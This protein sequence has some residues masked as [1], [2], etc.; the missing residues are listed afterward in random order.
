[1]FFL[2]NRHT[3]NQSTQFEQVK[4]H[5]AKSGSMV[6]IVDAGRIFDFDIYLSYH[7]QIISGPAGDTHTMVVYGWGNRD[8]TDY[9]MMHN[10][11]GRSWANEGS[12][13]VDVKAIT[14]VSG[15]L[16]QMDP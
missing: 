1:M 16:I 2:I 6:G 15:C 4:Q 8:G 13:L 3:S 7:D 10:S 11:W 9:L 14:R 12:V 5:I